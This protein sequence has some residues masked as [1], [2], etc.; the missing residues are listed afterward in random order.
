MSLE[1]ALEAHTA[2]L[3]AH[4]AAL[5]ALVDGVGAAAGAA[6]GAAA[7]K[8][9]KKPEKKPKKGGKAK[10]WDNEKTHLAAFGAYLKGAETKPDRKRIRDTVSPILDHFGVEKVSEIGEDDREESYGYLLQLVAG[11]EEDELEGAEAVDLG[12]SNED[13]GD[14]DN[15]L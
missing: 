7:G 8:G 9:G 6:S 13:D 4:T 11:W 2:A 12:L 14:P 1:K 10:P 5:E 15:V 3:E